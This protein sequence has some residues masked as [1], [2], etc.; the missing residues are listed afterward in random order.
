MIRRIR[1][2]SVL[3]AAVILCA[4]SLL[5]ACGNSTPLGTAGESQT[6]EI[7]YSNS[8]GS[9]RAL[10]HVP[11]SYVPGNPVPVVVNIHGCTQTAEQWQ[12]GTLF[13]PVA[14]REGFIVVYPD[15]V[16]QATHP[17]ACWR[18]YL[19]NEWLRDQGD[20]DGVAGLTRIVMQRWDV[21][22]E[23]VYVLGASSGGFLTSNLGVAYPDLYA[24]LGIL[25]G[26]PYASTFLDA[27]NPVVPSLDK[28]TLQAQLAF[29]AMGS[30]ARVV[31]II[32]MH[33]DADTTVY[34]QNGTNAVRQWL[35]T[36]NLVASGSTTQPFPLTPSE[37]HSYAQD[38]PF[39][40]DV[41]DY[42]DASGCLLVRHIR[43]HGLQHLWPGGSDDPDLPAFIEPRAFN[44]AEAAWDFLKRYRK[45]GTSSPCAERA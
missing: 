18:F 14:D 44:G 30:H 40:Y 37:T 5:P 2:F 16:D 22:P 11:G 21:D 24:A 3:K 1:C 39:P 7:N 41:D 25:A 20:V 34:P 19:P 17:L 32:E 29:Q 42:R 4:A 26:G 43:I 31:P 23:R 28:T 36:D 9:Y 12:A 38:E 13:D 6:F 8:Y 45:S 15:F 35:M 33:G 10:V 27:F